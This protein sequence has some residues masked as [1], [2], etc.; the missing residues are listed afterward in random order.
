MEDQ[1]EYERISE[2]AAGLS[3][4]QLDRKAHIPMFKDSPFGEYPTQEQVI[5]GLGVNRSKYPTLSPRHARAPVCALSDLIARRLEG[6]AD[7]RQV[8]Y[9]G[10][11]FSIKI[12]LRSRSFQYLMDN[13][14]I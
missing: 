2:F 13:L 14:R 3:A 8:F 11:E 7:C 10:S 6:V 4:E 5:G 9:R 12:S 1:Q